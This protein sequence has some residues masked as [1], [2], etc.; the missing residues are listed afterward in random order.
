MRSSKFVLFSLIIAFLFTGLFVPA[1]LAEAASPQ[2]VYFGKENGDVWDLQY[3]LQQQGYYKGKID[4]KFGLKT[5]Q[6]VIKYQKHKG[7][8]IDGIAGPE[9]W[10][11]L[12]RNSY[13]QED[14]EWLARAVYS[15]ARGEP[16]EGQVAV[17]AVVLNRVKSKDFPNTIKDV[18]FQKN[19]FTAV[20]DKQIWLTPNDTAYRAALDAIRGNDPSQGSL[21]YFNPSTATSKWIWTRKQNFKIGN[22]IFAS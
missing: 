10:T 22:H 9:T 4:G 19:A 16:Y 14:V 11:S 15:E 12:K 21:Y 17:A 18:I 5:E 6:A 2:T 20:Q 8:R 13:S 7:L 3:R 1:N